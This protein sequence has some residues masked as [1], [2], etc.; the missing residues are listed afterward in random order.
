M[1]DYHQQNHWAN[2]FGGQ[3]SPIDIDPKIT[4]AN[5]QSLSFSMDTNYHLTKLI[6]DQTTIRLIGAGQAVIFNREF[7]LQQVHFHAPAEHLIDGQQYPFEVHLVHQNTI[8]QLLVVALMVNVAS[9]SDQLNTI[10]D[11]FD[12]NNDVD[13]N[14]DIT[15]W[16]QLNDRTGF[17][18]LGS[19]TTPPLTEGVEWIVLDAPALTISAAQLK[20]YQ[21]LFAP[22]NRIPQP[23]NHR[24]IY[25]L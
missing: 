15:E 23:L 2:G 14:I 7:N 9:P 10:L 20:R 24:H 22:N 6:N 3:Q 4:I 25:K 12:V 18:Y 13:V 16:L 21:S 8:G 11:H 1:L 17:H 19:L 5:Q